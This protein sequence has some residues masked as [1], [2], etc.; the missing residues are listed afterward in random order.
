MS[1]AVYLI[2]ALAMLFFCACS[3]KDEGADGEFYAVISRNPE[4]LDPQMAM[5]SQSMTVIRNTYALL[6]DT[7]GDGRLING[8]AES[9]S[10]SSDGLVYTFKL[11]DG[12]CWFGYDGRNGVPLTAYDY[13]YAFQR[14]FDPDTH[15]PYTELFSA[16]K[17]SRA[18]YGKAKAMS[19]LGVTAADEKTLVIELESPDCDF[20]KLLSHTASAP[21]N[22]ELFLS[23]QGRYGLSAADCYSCGA[24]YLSDWNYDPYWND[25]HITLE[26]I[27][28]NSTEGY[29]TYPTLINLEITSD[30][31]AQEKKSNFKTDAYISDSFAH[32]DKETAK[33]YEI[34]EYVNESSCLF[35][36]A[37]FEPF[38]DKNVRKALYSSIGRET[39]K[40]ALSEDSVY[41]D[42]IIPPS[43]TVSN[44][45]FRELFPLT[46]RTFS[47]SKSLWKNML[48]EY[49]SIDFN[50]STLLVSDELNSQ[51]LSYAV[52][53]DF[54]KEL[55][56][57]CQAVFMNESDY[58]KA[59]S[60]EEHIFSIDTVD[61][62]VNLS[63]AFLEA[64]YERS[65]YEDS[66][67][68]A[69][70]SQIRQC[71]DLNTKK[72]MV[73]KAENYLIDNAYVLPLSFEKKYLLTL[74]D[75]RDIYYD[76]YTETMLFK[77]AKK[78]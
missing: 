68:E 28:C 6:M 36:S 37:D 63:E 69:M 77:Y 64:V 71:P 4:N 24:F 15:S 13:E 44:K 5:D 32:Y 76:P 51:P 2:S 31:Q 67:Y 70:L 46:E 3:D 8:S 29:K 7:D 39:L 41:S 27:N 9:Y 78:D 21:C 38:S 35:L 54:Q 22:K 52:T 17:N 26:R 18:V 23:T 57:Y 59:L 43:I 19:E 20:L 12:L 34:K 72:D 11:R 65:G 25:N 66:E 40:E 48:A 49:P 16:I 74:K 53:A 45:S 75:T 61:C 14:I 50:S 62:G 42:N 58:R 33:D 73:S 55:D 47:G 10:V 56:L 60:A 30:R 1:R